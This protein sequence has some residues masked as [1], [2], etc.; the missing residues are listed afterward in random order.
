MNTVPKY[1][2]V[3]TP[4]CCCTS[5]TCML[6][7]LV[8]HVWT[9]LVFLITWLD[10][11]LLVVLGRILSCVV[12]SC[13]KCLSQ[14]QNY[15]TTNGHLA[16]LSC[17][18]AFIW[19]PRPRFYYCQQLRVCWC[20]PPFLTRG[21]VCRLQVLLGF[22]SVVILR[23]ESLGTHDHILLS[24]IRDSPNLEDQVPVFISPR[25]RVAQFY[26]QALG[27]LFVASYDSQGYSGSIRRRLHAEI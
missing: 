4:M 21:W 10:V 9:I 2:L 16:S 12:C 7:A 19:G 17:C 14:S 27:Y 22:A 5:V 3:Y 20:W 1:N 11:C 24:Q 18:Q 26:P 25:K 6:T 15:V 8:L 13:Y 23:S